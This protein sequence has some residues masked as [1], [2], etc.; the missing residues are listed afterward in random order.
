MGLHSLSDT[1]EQITWVILPAAWLAV[2]FA[3][4]TVRAA[5]ERGLNGGSTSVV[6]L[7]RPWD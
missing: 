2:E 7:R 4:L 6:T 3:P 1:L 5:R